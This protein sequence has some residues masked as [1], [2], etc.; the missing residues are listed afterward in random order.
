[1]NDPEPKPEPKNAAPEADRE[2]A[3]P[4]AA[5]RKWTAVG[6][7]YVIGLDFSTES[8]RASL[9][10]LGSP[11]V[12]VSAVH[13]YL[14]GVIQGRLADQPLPQPFALQ[15]ADDYLLAAEDLLRRVA[16]HLPP[17]PGWRASAWPSP[18]VRR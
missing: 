7:T 11:E 17:G 9:M 8:A 2:T 15:D 12:L 4:D 3:T 13:P 16:A 18:P 14:H 10:R 5:L 1:M 6:Q